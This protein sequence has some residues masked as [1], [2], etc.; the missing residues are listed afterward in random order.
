MATLASTLE[1]GMAA[2][3]AEWADS[4]TDRYS[5]TVIVNSYL[6]FVLYSTDYRKL[7]VTISSEVHCKLLFIICCHI[8]TIHVKVTAGLSNI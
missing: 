1:L 8:V 5:D 7:Q 6:V 2:Y 3:H 4:R